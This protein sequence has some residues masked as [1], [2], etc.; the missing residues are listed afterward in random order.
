MNIFQNPHV[1]TNVSTFVDEKGVMWYWSLVG[2]AFHP[3]RQQ[4]RDMK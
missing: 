3:A 2:A 4:L 1:Y